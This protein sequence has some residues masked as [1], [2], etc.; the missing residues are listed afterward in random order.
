MLTIC[1]SMNWSQYMRLDELHEKRHLWFD[2]D[3][4]FANF[5]KA[6]RELHKGDYHKLPP[7]E[8]WKPIVREIDHFFYNL[9]VIPDSKSMLEYA[10]TL[11]GISLGVLTAL[12]RPTGK[13]IQAKDDK[14]RWVKDN[15]DPH[16]FT[17]T[18]VGGINKGKF[19]KSPQDILV[20]DLQRNIDA[21]RKAGGI[22]ILHTS[23]ENTIKQLKEIFKTS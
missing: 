20:D 19:C 8:F 3:G 23:P 21:W 10:K 11:K 6:A 9:E 7:S 13:A 5:E 22:G 18:V 17:Q 12:P 1:I 15:L 4:V 2:L 14:I 16:L